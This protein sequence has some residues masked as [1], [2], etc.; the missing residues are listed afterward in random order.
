MCI[1]DSV[2]R[3]RWLRRPDLGDRFDRR[4]W[5][6]AYGRLAWLG[7]WDGLSRYRPRFSHPKH[8][9]RWLWR[10]LNFSRLRPNDLLRTGKIFSRNRRVVG[11][12][13]SLLQFREQHV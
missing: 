4:R 7:L 13:P 12:A 5:K 3:G 2:S 10:F 6:L 11:V 8:W 9:L 1:R